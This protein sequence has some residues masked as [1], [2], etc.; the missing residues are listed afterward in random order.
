MEAPNQALYNKVREAREQ[1]QK[2]T[3]NTRNPFRGYSSSA[4]PYTPS[5]LP[6]V[7]W[8]GLP[9]MGALG[10]AVGGHLTTTGSQSVYYNA[11]SVLGGKV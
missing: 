2:E 8:G 5:A 7:G 3:K 11:S 1:E 6:D 10:G 4:E 9:G